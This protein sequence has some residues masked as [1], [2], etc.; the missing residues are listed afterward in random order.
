M[1]RNIL[2]CLCGLL[3]ASF[4]DARGLLIPE[5]KTLPPLAMVYHRVDIKIEDQ[6]AL[7]TV[8]QSFRNHTDRQLEA[9]YIFPIPKG[10]SVD[11]FTMWFD[12][13]EQGGE[14]LDSKQA[15]K[16]Y[17]DIV[18]RTQDPGLL[19]YLGNGMMRLRVFPVLPKSDQKVKISYKSIA[20]KDNGVIE[21]IYPLKVSGKAAKTLEDFTVKATVKAQSPIQNLYSPTHAIKQ[22]RLSDKEVQFQFEKNQAL[23]DKDF[24]VFY[25]VSDKEIGLTPLMYRPITKEDGYFMLLIS[26]DLES[27][28][29]TSVPRDL[30]LVLDTSGSMDAVKMDQAKKALKH[31]LDNLRSQD[32]F[33]IVTFSTNVRKYRDNLVEAS[34]EQLEN[35]KKWVDSLKAGGGTAIQAAL[36][37]ALDLREPSNATRPFTMVFF[38]DGQPTIGEMKPE[39]I[40]KNV[41]SKNTSN[42]RIFTF[43]VGDDVNAAMLDQL[44]EQTKAVSTYVR[45]AEDIEMKVASLYGKISHPVLANPKLTVTGDVKLYE[46]YPT[47]LPDLFF[48]TQLVVIGKYSGSGPVAVRL[49]GQ[50][51]KETKEFTYDVTFSGKTDNDGHEFVEALWARRKVGFLLDQIRLNGEQKE[52]MEEMIALA[53]KY[54]IA[55]PYTS[56]LVV[57][58]SVLVPP[59]G[60]IARP[61][62][63]EGLGG[64]GKLPSGVAPPKAPVDFLR[65]MTGLS[66]DANLESLARKI[67]E[68]GTTQQRGGFEED[69]LNRLKQNLDKALKEQQELAKKDPKK[70]EESLRLVQEAE[71]EVRDELS[72]LRNFQAAKNDFT[73]GDYR[74]NQVGAVG[75]DLAQCAN[76]LRSQERLTASASRF[77][78]GRNCLEVAG[79]WIDEGFTPKMETISIKSQ[80]DA[81]FKL[82]EKYPKLKEVYQLGNRIVFVTPSQVALIIDEDSGRET[83]KDEEIEK[84][85][86]TNKN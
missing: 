65:D 56:Y 30:V 64:A 79:V 27:N 53:K 80:S 59:P 62:F 22:T 67:A 35:A 13:K 48:G 63:G 8:E 1:Y 47:I 81:Y 58:D 84:L 24:Q 78:Y 3:I 11:K 42:T 7:T 10:A 66:Q 55:T 73:K 40:L 54:G 51:G 86:K 26:P 45:P 12:G 25:S 41:E 16:I 61:N 77:V 44:A 39:K 6:V 17:T 31:C 46:M 14:L 5:E 18:R 71:R 76:T 75:V 19:E 70:A 60:A 49:T 4:A 20:T 72:K 21:Y 69:R 50:L 37:T 83:L 82:L 57:P 33:A 36:D 34:S 32:R 85:F 74:K 38:T 28:K 2:P 68:K 43:G 15:S 9:T 52:L 23:L 29:N